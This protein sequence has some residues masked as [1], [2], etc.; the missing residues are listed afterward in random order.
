MKLGIVGNGRL[1]SH[2][3]YAW[4]QKM[5]KEHSEDLT[6]LLRKDT[7]MPGKALENQSVRYTDCLEEFIEDRDIILLCVQDDQ[8]ESLSKQIKIADHQ[9][10]AHSSGTVPSTILKNTGTNYGVW[11]P[12]QTFSITGKQLDFS[13]IPIL[14]HAHTEQGTIGLKS[15]A[16]RLSERVYEVSDERRAYVHLSA[17]FANNF[18][19][20]LLEVAQEILS[21]AELPK[22]ILRALVQE[23]VDKFFDTPSNQKI[24]TGPA[25][26]GDQKTIERH[27]SAL[28]K[29]PD[30]QSIYRDLS[31]SIQHFHQ[32]K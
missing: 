8:I 30:L 18:T 27:L 3:S 16:H 29:N 9:I 23:T 25:I 20:H 4:Q 5:G 24:Q 19:N 10:I 2:L 1:S 28:E 15:L 11:Y 7:P 13:Q 31:K 32:K 26:R 21:E 14:V 17:V 22:D 12:L 6:I